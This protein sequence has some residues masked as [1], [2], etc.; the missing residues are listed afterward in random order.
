MIQAPLAQVF[1]SF[2]GEGP[3]VGVRQVFVRV[4]GCDLTCRYCDTPC[5][6]ELEGPC[7]VETEP[8]S[9][10]FSQIESPVSIEALAQVLGCLCPPPQGD[11]PARCKCCQEKGCRVFFAPA[12]SLAVT[13]GEP[14]LYPEF[15]SELTDLA[16]AMALPVYLE[17]GGHRPLEL[18]AV[19]G[20]VAYVSM[21]Y[22]LPSTLSAPV[23][24]SLFTASYEVAQRCFWRSVKMVVTAETEEDEVCEAARALSA[25]SDVGPLTIQPVTAL[26][27]GERSPS[28]SQLARLYGAAAGFI[29]DVRVIG[30]CH[31]QMGVL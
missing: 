3:L 28:A 19:V 29:R 2:Q 30:Q 12:H 31:R 24:P 10:E 20:K 17:T 9:G 11:L 14:L 21:D 25:V 1:V 22:K 16:G 27:G 7:D 26:P 18:E 5:A 4:R 8:G 13:G 23:D 6:R 15:V